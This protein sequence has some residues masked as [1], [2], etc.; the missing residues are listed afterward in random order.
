MK[1]L[2]ILAAALMVS[3]YSFG[4]SIPTPVDPCQKLDTNSIKKM[5]Q[6]TWVDVKDSNHIFIVT[7]DSVEET[8]VINMNGKPSVNQS[9]WNYK[10]TD[11]VFSTD[12]V[13]CYS[14]VEY[15]EGYPHNVELAINLLDSHYFI[16]GRTGKT[17]Y[18][19]KS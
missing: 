11:N 5:L 1:S 6:G 9:F 15:K 16:I 12:A 19:R 4:Q 10:F 8:I 7:I 17:I 18:R 3:I 13:T 14:L 2:F